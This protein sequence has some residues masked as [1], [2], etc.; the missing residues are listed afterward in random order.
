[1]D[2]RYGIVVEAHPQ[3]HSVDVIM[4]DD[5]SRLAGVQVLS[6]NGGP[7]VGTAD[8]FCPEIKSG[9]DKWSMARRSALDLKAAILFGKG[10]PIVIGFIYPQ[11]GQMTF[12]DKN[13]RV[14]RHSSDVYETI[15]A[16]GNYERYFPNGSFIRVGA[17]PDHED[18][19]GKDFDKNWVITKN[20]GAATHFRVVLGNAGV[21]KADIHLDPSGNL[22]G[23][24]QGTGNITTV[25]D[26]TVTAPH[27]TVNASGAATVNTATAT[28]NASTKVELATPLVHCTTHLIVDGNALVKGVLTYQGGMVGS[29]GSGSS[30]TITGNIAVTSGNVTADGIGLKTHH[31]VEHDGPST[32]AAVA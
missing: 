17:S 23:T 13:R 1:M 20:T 7:D 8:M 22:T 32:G 15:D 31:H 29:G 18:L 9:D 28:I 5:Y 16:Q 19:T 6:Y 11:V 14:Q 21:V 3:D 27:V 12:A 10:M 4:T 26:L 30:A 24:F 25:G 2:L